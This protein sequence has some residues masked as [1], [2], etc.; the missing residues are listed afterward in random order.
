MGLLC[1]PAEQLYLYLC[2]LLSVR[3][4]LLHGALMFCHTDMQPRLNV[5]HRV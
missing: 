3:L 5:M 4:C 2:L 1:L